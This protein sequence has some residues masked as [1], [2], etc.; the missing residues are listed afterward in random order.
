MAEPRLTPVEARA[1]QAAFA[2]VGQENAARATA[3]SLRTY[4]RIMARPHVIAEKHRVTVS[5]LRA[6]GVALARHAEGAATALGEMATG[7]AAPQGAKV[8][9]C[10]AVLEFAARWIETEDLENRIRELEANAATSQP[11]GGYQ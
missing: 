8:R 10:E 2:H 11:E 1:V 5:K 3:V 6:I 7:A 9:A 4:S